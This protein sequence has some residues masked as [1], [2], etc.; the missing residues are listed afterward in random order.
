MRYNKIEFVKAVTVFDKSLL[1]HVSDIN[2]Q[3]MKRLVSQDLRSLN[4]WIII[5]SV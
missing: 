5:N 1:I 2:V 3:I 4:D